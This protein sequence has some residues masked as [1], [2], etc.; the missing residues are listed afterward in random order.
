MLDLLLFPSFIYHK[1]TLAS[2]PFLSV[3]S[4]PISSGFDFDFHGPESMSC[5]LWIAVKPIKET[6]NVTDRETT[7][8]VTKDIQ[9]GMKKDFLVKFAAILVVRNSGS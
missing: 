2:C 9:N 7:R 1:H 4:F 3:L 5:C 8:L 6:N